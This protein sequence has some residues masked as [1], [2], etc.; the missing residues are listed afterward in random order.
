MTFGSNLHTWWKSHLGNEYS[1][2]VYRRASIAL[3]WW[4]LQKC[5]TQTALKET[6]WAL[7]GP[8]VSCRTAGKVRIKCS[9]RR[10]SVSSDF[11]KCT[12]HYPVYTTLPKICRT[13][14]VSRWVGRWKA[15]SAVHSTYEALC[16]ATFNFVNWSLA[17]MAACLCLF[18][19]P[20]IQR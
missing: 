8:W 2:D 17:S 7:Y 11:W 12:L 13:A 6:C 10:F 3:V 19:H 9:F 4:G 14:D 16:V 20:F 5:V 1:C 18:N 15:G